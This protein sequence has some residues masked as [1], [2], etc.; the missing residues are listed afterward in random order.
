ME[1]V[2]LKLYGKL[3]CKVCG[4]RPCFTSRSECHQVSYALVCNCGKRTP[5]LRTMSDVAGKWESETRILTVEQ[6]KEVE[7]R[8]PQDPRF[9]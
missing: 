6:A 2:E 8:E 4:E 7:G 3:P 9:T 5:F 1:A